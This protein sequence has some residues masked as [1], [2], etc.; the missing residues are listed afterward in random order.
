[1]E[2]RPPPGGALTLESLVPDPDGAVRYIGVILTKRDSQSRDGYDFGYKDIDE[3]MGPNKCDCPLRILRSASPYKP[4]AKGYG[5]QWRE[6]CFAH[7][8]SK[9]T[10]KMP[11]VGTVFRTSQPV[12][13]SNGVVSSEFQVIEIVRRGKAAKAYTIPGHGGVYRF[14]PARFGATLEARNGLHD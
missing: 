3:S 13:F 10:W 6:K 5:P 1:M 7:H 8:K 11:K 12:A 2:R 9:V 14:N 4:D